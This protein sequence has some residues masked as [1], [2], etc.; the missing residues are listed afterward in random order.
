M[1]VLV[2]LRIDDE[3]ANIVAFT[4]K[5]NAAG[6]DRYLVNAQAGE[7]DVVLPDPG[8][9]PEEASAYHGKW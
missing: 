8:S 9:F 5:P 4:G 6:D 3:L 7:L 1:G 2:D